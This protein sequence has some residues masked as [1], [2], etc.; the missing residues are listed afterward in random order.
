MCSCFHEFRIFSYFLL[1]KV[2]Y[3]HKK[4]LCSYFKRK[5]LKKIVKMLWFIKS[6]YVIYEWPLSERTGN[7]LI[8]YF[9]K[10]KAKQS[11]GKF[12]NCVAKAIKILTSR[13]RLHKKDRLKSAFRI[14]YRVSTLG[15]FK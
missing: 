2:F 8:K 6:A 3:F 4:T 13:C 12:I 9:P 5:F 14:F 10:D 1:F 11:F 7:A 15:G